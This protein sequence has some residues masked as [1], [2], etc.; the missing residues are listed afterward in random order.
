[1]LNHPTLEKLAAFKLTGMLKALEEQLQM[2]EAATL[3]FE[4]RLGLLVDR[5]ALERQN[6]QLKGRLLKARLRQAAVLEDV[7][8]RAPRGLDKSV[9]LALGSC[10]WIAQCQNCLI[11]GPTGV[12]KSWLAC[13]LGHKA[14]REGYSVLYLRL[15]RLWRELA[16]ARGDGRYLKLLAG[17]SRTDL[18][19][20]DDLGTEAL[21]EAER[22]DLLEIL[23]DRYERRSTL[24]TSQLPVGHWHQTIGDPTLADAILDRL[25]HNA[26][27]LA[28]KGES[29]RKKTKAAA[30]AE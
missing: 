27:K 11:T 29:L 10:Q 25:V 21:G 3:S 15:A 26:H 13:A 17:L 7:D 16:V 30:G 19:I 20:L 22:H 6:R 9:V 5:E 14:C 12:G 28:L 23:E 24:V 2:R 4:E 8:W 1:M 18:I